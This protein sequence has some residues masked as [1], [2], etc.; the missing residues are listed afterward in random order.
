MSNADS[1]SLKRG[2]SETDEFYPWILFDPGESGVVIRVLKASGGHQEPPELR[3]YWLW[4][5]G[6]PVTQRRS[7]P[8]LIP[9]PFVGYHR[10]SE[11]RQQC[12]YM[13]LLVCGVTEFIPEHVGIAAN[14]V[15]PPSC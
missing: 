3:L 1:C 2:H 6:S 8:G 12:S 14:T 15:A 4:I 7:A 9:C 13:Y 10:P 5:H 11:G